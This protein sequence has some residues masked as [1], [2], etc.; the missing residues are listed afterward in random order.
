MLCESKVNLRLQCNKLSIA[1]QPE[2]R[3]G[4]ESLSYITF[5]FLNGQLTF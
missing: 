2:P 5:Y 4:Q 1:Q 3:F